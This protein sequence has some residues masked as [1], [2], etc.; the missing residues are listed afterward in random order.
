MKNLKKY[1]ILHAQ[2]RDVYNALTNKT[3]L[4][5]WTGEPAEMEPVAGS[6][7]S[8]WDGSISGI[9]IE[10]EEGKKIVQQ[11]FF[12]GQEAESIVTI[13]LHQHQKGTSVEL[14]HTNIPDE[15]YENIAE[16][17]DEDYFGSLSELFN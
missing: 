12:E 7:F 11:W 8:L 9:N 3:M 17:W 14:V 16:G 13:K 15:A 1:Y 5:I 4:E 10:F 2:P 6:A